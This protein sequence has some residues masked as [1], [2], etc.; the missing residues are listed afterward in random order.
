PLS[1]TAYQ[2]LGY[3]EVIEG[4]AAGESVEKMVATITLR[5]QQF[6]VRQER[7]YRR[8]PRIHW[9][10]V[11]KDPISEVTPVLHSLLA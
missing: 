8:D 4:L 1:K 3:K 2:A 6:A 7:W 5:T 11:Q 10:Q 9:V